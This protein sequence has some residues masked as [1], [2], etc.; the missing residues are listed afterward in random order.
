MARSWPTFLRD[1]FAIYAA[2]T[3]AP[4]L[5]MPYPHGASVVGD[6]IPTTLIDGLVRIGR[7]V[8]PG[9]DTIL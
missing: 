7:Q 2:G 8:T 9:I 3:G 5:L 6:P 4:M 1:E